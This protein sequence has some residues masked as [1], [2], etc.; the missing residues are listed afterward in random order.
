MK[1]QRFF[2]LKNISYIYLFLNAAS[3]IFGIFYLTFSFDSI[4]LDVFG[5]I[6]M[7]AFFGNFI[8]IIQTKSGVEFI[9]SLG[10]KIEKLCN[11][12]PKFVIIGKFQ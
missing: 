8:M 5:F 1:L 12:Y 10:K 9:G 4:V 3:V 6:L 2:S 7:F 11:F